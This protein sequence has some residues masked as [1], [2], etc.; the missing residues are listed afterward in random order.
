MLLA[1]PG[2]LL[3]GSTFVRRHV[4][5]DLTPLRQPSGGPSS[6]TS[7]TSSDRAGSL[8]G[9]EPR[10]FAVPRPSTGKEGSI[11]LSA[12][13]HAASEN[14]VVTLSSRHTSWLACCRQHMPA[15]YRMQQISGYISPS[16]KP[17]G[18]QAFKSK[19]FSASGKCEKTFKI[20][21]RNKCVDARAD[22]VSRCGIRYAI[23]AQDTPCR[24]CFEPRSYRS[25]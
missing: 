15:Y 1:A 12:G 11:L 21:P 10:S 22:R 16:G 23:Q 13:F 14:F 6:Q 5:I 2:V 18:D 24:R 9:G 8:A 4:D 19:C 17:W 7:K 3:K 25:N 20:R